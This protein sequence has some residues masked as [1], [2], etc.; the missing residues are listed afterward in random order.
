VVEVTRRG[1]VTRAVAPTPPGEDV[2]QAAP[3]ET[4]VAVSTQPRGAQRH[5]VPP[6]VTSHGVDGD[7]DNVTLT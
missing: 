6:R 1:A 3:D 4:R 2:T 5:R 7:F